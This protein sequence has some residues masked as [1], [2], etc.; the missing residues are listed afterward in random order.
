MKKV[1]AVL[2][3]AMLLFAAVS[4]SPEAE[5]GTSLVSF[6]VSNKASKGDNGITEVITYGESVVQYGSWTDVKD[7]WDI[8]YLITTDTNTDFSTATDVVLTDT[9]RGTWVTYTNAFRVA[10][11][12]TVWAYCENKEEKLGNVGAAAMFKGTAKEEVKGTK[13]VIVLVPTIDE[14]IAFANTTEGSLK[15][16]Q[17]TYIVSKEQK[18]VLGT[19]TNI[20]RLKVTVTVG[21]VST[22]DIA[23]FVT[24]TDGNLDYA[25]FT[26]I[27]LTNISV[28]DGY[29]TPSDIKVEFVGLTSNSNEVK[30][31]DKYNV[32]ELKTPTDAALSVYILNSLETELKSLT[33]EN[34]TIGVGT[35]EI[36]VT[37]T[38]QFPHEEG[39]YDMPAPAYVHSFSISA[40]KKV[41]LAKGNVKTSGSDYVICDDCFESGDYYLFDVGKYISTTDYR[42]LTEDEW[43]YL[44][45]TRTVNGG[46]G[47][48]YSFKVVNIG[49]K[50]GAIF[51]PDDFNGELI[52][53]TDLSIEEW[54]QLKTDGCI[55]MYCAGYNG[56]EGVNVIGEYWTCTTA[57][58]D[59]HKAVAVNYTAS[60]DTVAVY[61]FKDTLSLTVRLAMDIDE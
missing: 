51:F 44:I 11:G 33:V 24:D 43:N 32:F 36:N 49:D 25:S 55:F 23:E 7:A 12:V 58:A 21:N 61:K 19:D 1:L 31:D 16:D 8:Y 2:L 39:R 57:D 17:L 45:N 53:N 5:T 9:N 35:V 13:T 20:S 27:T 56:N 22:T 41:L 54:N 60:P 10:K 59:S 47:N 18:E 4:C 50:K 48:G 37:N 30:L 52:S 46:T 29:G 3:A 26:N 38:N 34:R 6:K 40:N 42:Q 28:S 15:I 14:A